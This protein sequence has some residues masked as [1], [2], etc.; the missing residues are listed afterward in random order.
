MPKPAKDGL[1]DT[2]LFLNKGFRSICAQKLTA[3]IL[4]WF[5]NRFIV[6]CHAD[7]PEVCQP[8]CEYHICGKKR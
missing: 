6:V 4:D 7:G 5:A 2:E 8:E 1:T 3:A